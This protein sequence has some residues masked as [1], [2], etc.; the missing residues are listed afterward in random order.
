MQ[1][2][3]ARTL[4]GSCEDPDRRSRIFHDGVG[5]AGQ[6]SHVDITEMRDRRLVL[7][8]QFCD[9]KERTQRYVA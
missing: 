9:V 8:F 1:W 3:D 7:Y 2:G 4:Q 6:S 5:E